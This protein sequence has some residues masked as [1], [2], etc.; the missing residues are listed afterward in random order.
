QTEL[1]MKK[2]AKLKAKNKPMSA[3]MLSTD[4]NPTETTSPEATMRRAM[5]SQ[6]RYESASHLP[7]EPDQQKVTTDLARRSLITFCI[8]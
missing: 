5:A 4:S 1:R 7:I 6:G 3:D 2:L 8:E